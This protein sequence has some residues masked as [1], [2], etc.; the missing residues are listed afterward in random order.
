LTF[1][2]ETFRPRGTRKP[3]GPLRASPL[4]PS[5]CQ[6]GA[7]SASPPLAKPRHHQR[8][9]LRFWQGS[10]LWTKKY[11]FRVNC[12]GTRVAMAHKQ[13]AAIGVLRGNCLA[14]RPAVRGTR[15]GSAR[16]C[17]GRPF[18]LA[19][20]HLCGAIQP[21]AGASAG[22]RPH[23]WILPSW[24][25]ACVLQAGATLRDRHS[26]QRTV[27]APRYSAAI[28]GADPSSL[29]ARTMLQ[30]AA[31]LAPLVGDCMAQLHAS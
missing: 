2:V 4:R 25:L 31:R 26:A 1:Y 14:P 17:C 27:L 6:G 28:L 5:R 21:K 7:A 18:W 30:S 3:R 19:Q 20:I 13:W 23:R 12:N 22:E 11:C 16:Q 15:C 8:H 29:L 9:P 10:S 24:P